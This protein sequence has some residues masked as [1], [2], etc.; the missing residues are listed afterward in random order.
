VDALAQRQHQI[1][2]GAL[3]QRRDLGLELG[4]P[5]LVLGLQAP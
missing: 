4:P 3:G 2:V 1:P 5:P